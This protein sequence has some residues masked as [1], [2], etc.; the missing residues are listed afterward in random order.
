MA[1]E[2]FGDIDLKGNVLYNAVAHQAASDPAGKPDGFWYYNTATNKFMFQQDGVF[3]D[4]GMSSLQDDTTPILSGPL[5][6]NAH[7]IRES[8]GTNVASQTSLPLPPNGNY[9]K[10]TG[11]SDIEGIDAIF[12]GLEVELEFDSV[13]NLVHNATSFI[14]PTATTI[15]TAAGDTARFREMSAGNW[16]CTGYTRA[17]GTPLVGG[18]GFSNPMTTPGDLIVGGTAGAPQRLAKGTS[19]QVLNG[20]LV[21]VESSG[22]W[23]QER[24]YFDGV[25]LSTSGP[26]LFF[27]AKRRLYV[28][29]IEAECPNAGDTTPSIN[30]YKNGSSIG[31]ANISI[32]NSYAHT[33]NRAWGAADLGT[34]AVLEIGDVFQIQ[35]VSD[36]AVAS[37][38]SPGTPTYGPLDVAAFLE[39]A[40]EV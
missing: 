1:Y 37:T 40:P 20:D 36:G 30:L 13:L 17:A 8:L 14:L 5:N 29:R 25:S 4:F 34:T 6:T 27:A 10:I 11:N 32:N 31:G 15:V 39:L 7:Q 28:K 3:S 18:G 12:V 16:K 22:G 9:F 21:W 38:A 19:T 24:S 2:F 35:V 26:N 33:I 23:V